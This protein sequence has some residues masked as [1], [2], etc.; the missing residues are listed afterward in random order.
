MY[1]VGRLGSYISRGV[2]TFSGPFHPFGGAVDIIVVEQPD[3]SFKSSPWYVK[4]GKFQGVLKSRERTVS[5]A[6]NGVEANFHMFLDH[7]GEAYFLREIDVEES[8][9]DG[10]SF[11]FYSGDEPLSGN[12][13]PMKSESCSYDNDN[14]N[15]VAQVDLGNGKLVGRTSSR[16]SRI[17]GRVFG[18]RSTKEDSYQDGAGGTGVMRS[19]SL[20]RAEFAAELLEVK[21]STNLTSIRSNNNALRFSSSNDALTDKGFKEE[22]QNDAENLSQAYVHDKEDKSIDRQTVLDKTDYCNEQNVSCSHTGLE[23]LE[24]SVEEANVQVFRV[25][26]EQQIVETSLLGEGFMED[27]CKVI[28]NVLG[29]MDD[30]SVRNFDHAD[31]ETVAVSGMS[32]PDLQSEYKFESC[33]DKRFD[34][35]VA[36]NESNVVLPGCGISNKENVS[37]GP[38][39]F[40][41][42]KT[43]ESSE[44]TLDCS[45]QQTHQ[46]LCLSDIENGKAHVHAEPLL[47][48]TEL[49]PEVTVLKKTEDKELDSEGVLTMSVEMVGVDPVIG[50]EET[51]SH[52]IHITS[53]ISDL[54]DDVENSRTIKDVLH[55]SLGSVDDSQNFYGDS[56]PKRSVPPSATSE[57]EQFLFSDLDEFKLHEPD[58]VNKDLHSSICTETEEVNG[59]CNVN[60]EPCLNPHNFVQEIPSTDMDFSV[61][62]AGIVSNPISIS[63]NHK[64]AGEKNG[65]QIES[66][67]TTWPIVAKFDVKNNLPLSHSL[68]SSCETLKWISIKEDDERPLAHGKSSYEES[69]TSRKLEST[70]YNPCIG[71]PSKAVVSR[72][73]SWRLW[74]FSMKKSI[75]RKDVLPAPADNRGL[76]AKNAVD[77][78]VASDDDKNVLKPK[79]VKKMIRAIT[80]TSEQ[81]ASLNLKDGINHITFTFSTSML[82]KQQVD[83][84][85]YLWKWNTHIVISDVDGT[86]TR[87]DVLGQFMPMVGIDWL[88]T[89]VAHL[90]S[91]I[92]ENGYELLFLSARA[93]SQAYITRQFLVNL[94]QDGKGLPDG[95][96]VISPDGLFP[97]LYR[98]VIRRAPHEFKIACLEDIKALF[99]LDCNPFY[100]GFGNRD[101]D[102]MSYLKVGIPKGKIF[103]INPKGEVVTNHHVATKSYSSLHDLVHRVFPP[104]AS[105]QEEF[106]SWN[107]WKLPP[108]PINI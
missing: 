12:R 14:S 105:E 82:G 83:A 93:I 90:F 5:I 4:F 7:T 40:V 78:A 28:A 45:S 16:R 2:F 29:T 106:N 49:V 70:L 22:I 64:V 87:S 39:A 74:P 84:R 17:F 65:W 75:S 96:I 85:I 59:L 69:E 41:Y 62:K 53:T 104:M 55:P 88:Q 47:R 10:V 80:P 31:N 86:I 103:T 67:P 25:S 76:D 81:L 36:D 61:E 8:K 21:W 38:Q 13:K 18:E 43:S 46:T 34:E 56:D 79:Q 63:R 23:N 60:K 42:C 54:G 44:I 32:V 30:L 37:D 15:S 51:K 107:F 73:G 26:T 66:L 77:G 50:L 35:E 100:A 98:E 27:K 3:G 9:S 1:A 52:S 6:V 20:E 95:P 99:P 57:D 92:K 68:D 19:E 102:E 71:Y 58:C 24:C 108:P 94:K 11:P 48:A 89:G 72:S 101:T 91:A 97:S 33:I